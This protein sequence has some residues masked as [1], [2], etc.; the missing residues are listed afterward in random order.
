MSDKKTAI[1]TGASGGI[2]AGLVDALLKNSYNV[3]AT[4]RGA[5]Q[6]LADRAKTAAP[7]W[8]SSMAISVSPRP[9]S[10]LLKLQSSTSEPSM[11]W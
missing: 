6:S 8:F 2:G 1:V 9:Q 4:S 11:F 10:K 5:S 7:V 3:V